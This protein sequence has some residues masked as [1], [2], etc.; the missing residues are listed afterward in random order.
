MSDGSVQQPHL[1]A[2]PLRAPLRET[3]GGRAGMTPPR[4]RVWAL[5]SGKGGVGKSLI[6]ANLGSILAESDWP[7]L[8]VDFDRAGPNLHTYLGVS[9]V[10]QGLGEVLR[11]TLPLAKAPRPHQVPGLGYVVGGAAEVLDEISPQVLLTSLRR[12][13]GSEE[14][15]VS[16]PQEILLDCASGVADSTLDVFLGADVPVMVITPDP[17]SVE[18]AH[19]FLGL[20]WRRALRAGLR[21]TLSPKILIE[22]GLR[23]LGDGYSPRALLAWLNARGASFASPQE[24]WSWGLRVGDPPVKGEGVSPPPISEG[25]LGRIW[26]VVPHLVVNRVNHPADVDVGF[27][28]I[29]AVEDYFGVKMPYL[30]AIPEDPGV[31]LAVQRRRLRVREL[32]EERLSKGLG[33]IADHIVEGGGLTPGGDRLFALS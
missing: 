29:R 10:G 3:I 5:A 9:G 21:G 18:N 1:D 14:S 20:A 12:F 31:S 7:T 13:E 16:R 6:T 19:R 15:G 30:G 23:A 26:P 8:V 4:P 22:S 2:A 17:A 27:A 24:D 11:G 25:D 32:G 33:I 28:M